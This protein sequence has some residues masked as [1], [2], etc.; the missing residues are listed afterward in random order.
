[1]AVR[2]PAATIGPHTSTVINVIFAAA[3]SAPSRDA[4]FVAMAR[5]HTV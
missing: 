4:R 2:P 3:P 5:P 1:M